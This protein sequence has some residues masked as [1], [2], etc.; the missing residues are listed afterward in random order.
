[1]TFRFSDF[2]FGVLHRFVKFFWTTAVQIHHLMQFDFSHGRSCRWWNCSRDVGIEGMH[3]SMSRHS[4]A[5]LNDYVPFSGSNGSNGC[6]SEKLIPTLLYF[7]CGIF[8]H[9]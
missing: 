5:W 3:V 4:A 7:E 6:K 8:K 1:M 9:T 2:P